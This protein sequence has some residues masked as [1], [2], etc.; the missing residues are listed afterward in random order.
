MTDDVRRSPI[1]LCA[2]ELADV[3]GGQLVAGR[4]DAEAEGV[5][6]DSRR[7]R[8]GDLFVAIRGDRFDGHAF[9]GEAVSRGAVGLV[10]SDV[11]VVDLHGTPTPRNGRP[12]VIAVAE[13][14]Q[15]LQRRPALPLLRQPL[16]ANR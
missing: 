14:I 16:P 6:I 15:A 1:A 8:A 11:S 7:V 12:F 2:G 10:V 9:V 3:V 5:A 13:T 4:L